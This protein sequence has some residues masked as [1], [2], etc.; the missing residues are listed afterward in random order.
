MQ[1]KTYGRRNIYYNSKNNNKSINNNEHNKIL[2]ERKTENKQITNWRRSTHC[3]T[4]TI[5]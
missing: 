2:P 1:L 5:P 4:I 3:D